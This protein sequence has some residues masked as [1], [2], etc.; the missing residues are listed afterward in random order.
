M[1]YNKLEQIFHKSSLVSRVIRRFFPNKKEFEKYV[2]ETLNTTEEKLQSQTVSMNDIKRTCQ[3]ILSNFDTG[4]GKREVEGF[5]SAFTYNKHGY[6]N[7]KDIS[8]IVYEYISPSLPPTPC[9]N[10]IAR[11]TA[12]S[13]PGCRDQRTAHHP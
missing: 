4:L 7:G 5:L 11:M 2:A 9:S 1:H 12:A 8:A 10:P 6:T 13:S 3:N